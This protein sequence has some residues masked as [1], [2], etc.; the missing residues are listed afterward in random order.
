MGM[1]LQLED[2]STA[3]ALAEGKLLRGDGCRPRVCFRRLEV[4]AGTAPSTAAV[5]RD[6]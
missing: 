5:D 6:C 4:D 2:V 3:E 1:K